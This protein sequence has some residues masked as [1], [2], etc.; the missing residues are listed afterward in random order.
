MAARGESHRRLGVVGSFLF[1]DDFMPAFVEEM[2]STG[3]MPWHRQGKCR[4][5]LAN[6]G[7]AIDDGG[8]D[9]TVDYDDLVAE[10]KDSP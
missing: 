4:Q 6:V 5:T 3:A 10:H 9:W 7:E 1:G 2:L 8:L